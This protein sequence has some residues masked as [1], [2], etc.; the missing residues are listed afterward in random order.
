MHN[1]VKINS[2]AAVDVSSAEVETVSQGGTI[3]NE[4]DTMLKSGNLATD[5]GRKSEG[6]IAKKRV[7]FL[8][9]SVA[10]ELI[11]REKTRLE[12]RILALRQKYNFSKV[13]EDDSDDD[14]VQK[15]NTG[16]EID[17]VPRG[18]LTGVRRPSSS[19]GFRTKKE[20]KASAGD[21]EVRTRRSYSLSRL[22]ELAKPRGRSK[23]VPPAKKSSMIT[24]S[25]DHLRLT[26]PQKPPRTMT[27][28]KDLQ[29]DDLDYLLQPKSLKEFYAMAD[30]CSSSR[31]SSR[32]SCSPTSHGCPT[33]R[34]QS[35]GST[36]PINTKMA[37]PA[38]ETV[39][40][41]RPPIKPKFKPSL[42]MAA[43]GV[44]SM[45]A[46]PK[47]VQR[48]ES[49]VAMQS[50]TKALSVRSPNVVTGRYPMPGGRVLCLR[51]RKP[52]WKEQADV[53]DGQDGGQ[54]QTKST[55]ESE[56]KKNTT[57]D[58]SIPRK[59]ESCKRTVR[60]QR[61]DSRSLSVSQLT[62]DLSKC[63]YLR[64]REQDQVLDIKEI[65]KK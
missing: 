65:F 14:N 21:A 43:T 48:Q 54:S 47:N 4:K 53:E 64:L 57:N 42:K 7:R 33:R 27:Q 16:N 15:R 38:T 31:V 18:L 61:P 60:Y 6:S 25:P 39:P 46:K 24:L 30:L 28:L 63:K 37:P 9:K 11:L 23:S 19:V 34:K 56:T 29:G 17:I 52:A 59:A 20:T 40:P 58:Q 5:G 44:M 12:D 8:D 13:T 49:S 35:A 22:N 51:P 41:T 26:I 2:V 36:R 55:D 32:A 45:S 3:H 1:Q 10:Q 50:W 62:R